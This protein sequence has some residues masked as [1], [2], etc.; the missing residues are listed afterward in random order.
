M[1]RTIRGG[2]KTAGGGMPGRDP[3][4]EAELATAAGG[5]DAYAELF[6]NLARGVETMTV[7]TLQNL[8]HLSFLP[9]GQ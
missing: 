2:V 6:Q 7:H 4:R 1:V 8:P 5:E 3:A 9:A